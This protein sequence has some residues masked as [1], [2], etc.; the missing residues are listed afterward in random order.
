VVVRAG[1]I[2]HDLNDLPST[3]ETGEKIWYERR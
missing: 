2:L 1:R 3:S